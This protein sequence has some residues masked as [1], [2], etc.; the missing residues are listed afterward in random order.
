MLRFADREDAGRR[1]AAALESYRDA[2]GL[3]VLG[4]PRGGVPVAAE[5]ARGLGAPMDVFLVRKLGV[6]AHPELAFGAIAGDGEVVLNREVVSLYGLDEASAGRV[7]ARERAELLRREELYRKGMPALE[8]G[9][10][11]V[12]LVD[13]GLATGATMKAAAAAVKAHGPKRVIVAVP[14]GAAETCA[15]LESVAD[16]VVCLATPE[17]F[18]AVGLWYENFDQTTDAQVLE[19]LRSAGTG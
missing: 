3:L 16:E 18:Q 14:V 6:P 19:L 1:L 15:D 13:D 10:R 9:G 2:P 12:I 11:T 4:L 7:A 5:V 8:L 17:P